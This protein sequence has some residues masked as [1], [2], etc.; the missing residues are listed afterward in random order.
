MIHEN[1]T[2]YSLKY[3]RLLNLNPIN[4][5]C[6]DTLNKFDTFNLKPFDEN[7]FEINNINTK[8]PVNCK[9][10]IKFK[11]VSKVFYFSDIQ[12]IAYSNYNFENF[13]DIWLDLP[14]YLEDLPNIS[15][16][17]YS[18][19]KKKNF[20]IKYNKYTKF[21]Y[22]IKSVYNNYY[23]LDSNYYFTKLTFKSAA[24]KIL[25]N[26][27]NFLIKYT[28]YL[29]FL[30][31]YITLNNNFFYTTKNFNLNFFFYKYLRFDLLFEFVENVLKVTELEFP[32]VR[33]SKL[34]LIYKKLSYTD[35]LQQVIEI[36]YHSNNIK[37]KI[38]FNNDLKINNNYISNLLQ[39]NSF[40]IFN[41]VSF[42][43]ANTILPEN[44]DLF[45]YI[46]YD[47]N[48]KNET[49]L[50]RIEL[51]RCIYIPSS[52]NTLTR[53]AKHCE[54]EYW[55]RAACVYDCC[56]FNRIGYFTKCTK[57]HQNC[58]FVEPLQWETNVNDI[59]NLK[60]QDKPISL[61]RRIIYNLRYVPVKK[62]KKF[63][64]TFKNYENTY[65]TQCAYGYYLRP[66][67]YYEN[68]SNYNFDFFF[69]KKF[70]L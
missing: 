5:S 46:C 58:F 42:Y 31:S 68:I 64:I 67:T 34:N 22:P 54:E 10:Y 8:Y 19:E 37:T 38:L 44:Y 36:M 39:T 14:L 11:Y 40:F 55:D 29:N 59:Y 63:R 66:F 41:K 53:P 24:Y 65:E 7:F 2:N 70:T 47:L 57:I 50:K 45:T 4:L 43:P 9:N 26:K 51:I 1:I 32:V 27:L 21:V 69:L 60:S 30:E 52:L 33:Y 61:K 35:Y 49:N 56:V 6:R 23:Y 3:W 28:M 48:F 16:L 62:K 25:Y 12:N 13:F 17:N 18:V 20:D 15:K